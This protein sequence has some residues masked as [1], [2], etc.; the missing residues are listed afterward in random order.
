MNKHQVHAKLIETGSNFRQFA[1]ANGYEPRTV[2]AVV[3]RWAGKNELPRGRLS[4]RILRDLS[5]AIGKE[6]TPGITQDAA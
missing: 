5:K 4:F 3:D 1:L 6:V 2:L